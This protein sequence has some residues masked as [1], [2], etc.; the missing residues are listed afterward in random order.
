MKHGK[1]IQHAKSSKP[2]Y[3]VGERV[4]IQ[5]PHLWSGCAGVV[6]KFDKETTL[7]L[8]AVTGKNGEMFHAEATADQLEPDYAAMMGV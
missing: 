8:L 4:V 5:R 2:P 1:G 6:E 3:A 7:H